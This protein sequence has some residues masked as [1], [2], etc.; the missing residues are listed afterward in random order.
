MLILREH[1][2]CRIENR[3][4]YDEEEITDE[5][6]YRFINN[7]GLCIQVLFI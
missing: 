1:Y 5:R 2:D 4:E 6:G 3:T 7:R